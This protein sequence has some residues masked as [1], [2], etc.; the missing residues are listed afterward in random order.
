M[1]GCKWKLSKSLHRE[2]HINGIA[3]PGE[4]AGSE[5]LEQS[6]KKDSITLDPH[7]RGKWCARKGQALIGQKARS[8]SQTFPSIFFCS[9]K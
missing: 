7:C 4:A 5:T 9:V 8:R 3:W 6:E 1:R 2:L